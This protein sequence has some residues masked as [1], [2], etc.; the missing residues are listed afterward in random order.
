MKLIAVGFDFEKEELILV[1][2]LGGPEVRIDFHCG[3]I[4]EPKEL[5]GRLKNFDFDK[6]TMLV[7]LDD[8]THT[9]RPLYLPDAGEFS[10]V[11]IFTKEPLLRDR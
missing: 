4:L 10:I 5:I 2:R 9:H 1:H 11:H 3:N 6:K 8:D 7:E